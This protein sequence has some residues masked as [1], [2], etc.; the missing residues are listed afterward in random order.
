MQN[1][2]KVLAQIKQRGSSLDTVKGEIAAGDAMELNVL[3]MESKEQR[4]S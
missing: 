4:S 3:S 2:V 1:P